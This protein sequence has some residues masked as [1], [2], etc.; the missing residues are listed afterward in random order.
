MHPPSPRL[1]RLLDNPAN[2]IVEPIHPKAMPVIL[3]TDEE[4]D[5]SMRAPWDEAKALQRPLAHDG[6]M[7][8]RRGADW[9]MLSDAGGNG[10]HEAKSIDCI[11]PACRDHLD[12]YL[13][14]RMRA[15]QVAT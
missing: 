11:D 3:T 5:V 14:Q 8:V 13:P 7:I 2:A 10:P 6:L 1:L 15:F 12:P 4:C 9:E